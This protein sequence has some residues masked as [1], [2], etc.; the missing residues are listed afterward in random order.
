MRRQTT[1]ACRL[2]PIPDTDLYTLSPLPPSDRHTGRR[3]SSTDPRAAPSTVSDDP[4]LTC[5]LRCTTCD[6]GVATAIAHCTGT[7]TKRRNAPVVLPTAFKM[8]FIRGSVGGD[9]VVDGVVDASGL[10]QVYA[11]P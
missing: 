5:L 6:R 7:L 3:L 2:C 4:L 8:C 1:L 10:G 9:D 11:L